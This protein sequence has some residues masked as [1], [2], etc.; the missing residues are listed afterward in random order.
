[1]ASLSLLL[2][3]A[4]AGLWVRSY[5]VVDV[6]RCN[7]HWK[8]SAKLGGRGI[9]IGSWNAHL[10]LIVFKYRLGTS[11]FGVTVIEPE[12]E[13]LRFDWSHLP[14]RQYS[15]TQNNPTWHWGGIYCDSQRMS[16]TTF[17]DIGDPDFV[18]THYGV[19]CWMVVVVT[20]LA[21]LIWHRRLLREQSRHRIRNGL[22]LKCGYD[23]R[24]SSDRCPE[25]GT[26]IPLDVERK[27]M[28]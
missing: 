9:G 11:R 26:Q 10:E 23:L 22:C 2:L 8:S 15:W 12:H 7:V 4:T 27:P 18:E 21:P 19:P 3:V 1:M 5:W 14:L 24:A 6:A 25:C 20:A 17:A 16:S 13:P 28:E